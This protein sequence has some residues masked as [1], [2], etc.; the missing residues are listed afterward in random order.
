MNRSDYHSD[1]YLRVM[2][3]LPRLD[4]K[5][6]GHV[7]MAYRHDWYLV[8]INPDGSLRRHSGIRL[9]IPVNNYQQ[10]REINAPH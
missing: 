9:N 1:Y 5:L 2:E 6:N 10:L 3:A 8:A 4:I 7:P